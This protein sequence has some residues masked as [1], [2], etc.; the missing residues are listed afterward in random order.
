M[1]NKEIKNDMVELLCPKCRYTEII[2]IGKESIE[3]CP[4]CG[5]RMVIKEILKEGKSY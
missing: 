3:K 1:K 5:N 4:V 2:N